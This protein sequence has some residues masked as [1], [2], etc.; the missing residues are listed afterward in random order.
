MTAL[1]SLTP[2]GQ[3]QS[4]QA[5]A[6]VICRDEA[7][8]AI[9]SARVVLTNESTG[10]SRVATT[11]K[12]GSFEARF[13]PLGRYRIEAS[14]PGFRT[15]TKSGLELSVGSKAA[16]EFILRI[17]AVEERIEVVAT[18]SQVETTNPLLSTL[19]DSRKI[20][21]LPLNGRDLVQLM[22]L[23]PGVQSARTDSGDIVTGSKGTRITV[24]G[25]RPSTNVFMLDG[26][27]INNL[28][29]RVAGGATGSLTGVETV[30]EF[31][32]Y[33][34]SY[35]AEFSRAA[36]GAFNIV[37]KSGTNALHGSAFE[38]LRN[39][40]LHARNFFD[41]QRPEFRRNQFGGSI[42][43]PIVKD[44]T[45]FF[46]SYE[47]FREQAGQTIIRTVPDADARLGRINGAL[48]GVAASVRPY[49]ALWPQPSSDP[50]PGDGSA[51]YTTVFSRPVTE[52]FFNARLD[53]QISS[54]DSLF[55]RYTI[56]DSAQTFLS[57]EAF[58]QYPN[59][60]TN[61]PQ[62]LTLQETKILS[63]F[64]I[65]ELRLGFAR[66]NPYEQLLDPSI[67]PDLAF[68]PGESLGVITIGGFD[69]FGPDRN[70]PRRLTQNSFQFSDQLAITRQRH[71][72]T[73]GLQ[74]ERLQ[75]NVISASQ[76]RGEFR[77]A[78]L[79][80]FLRA[81][82][83]TFEG[84]LPGSKDFTRGYRQ[85]LAGWYVQDAIKVSRRLTVNLGL[86]H[87]FVTVPTEQNGR[88]NN[89]HNFMDPRI[90]VGPPFTT[91]KANFAPRAGFALDPTGTGKT[92]IRGGIGFFFVPFVANQWWNSIVRLPPFTVTARATGAVA[93]FPAPVNGL[94]ALGRESISAI[95]YEHQQPYMLHFNF[96]VQ[97]AVTRSTILTVAYVGSRG[98]HLGRESDFNIG[99]PGNPVRRNPNFSRIRFRTWDARS[100][101]NS[102][103]TSLQRH[104]RGGAQFQLSYTLAKSVDDA[105][106]ELGRIEFNNGQARTSDPLDRLRDRGLSSFDIRQNLV[107][108][109]TWDLPWHRA[110]GWQLNGILTLSS[111][112]PFT[113][114]II[115]DL[116]QDGTDDNEQRPNLKPGRSKNPVL[117]R[118][119]H[120]FDVSAFES[121]AR[122]TRGNLGRNTISG[123]GL[124]ML[125]LSVARTFTLPK[126]ERARLQF[127][128]ESFNALNRANF[129]T[130][131]RSN[132][133]IFS[134][135]GPT[136]TPLPNAGR[137]NST[138]TSA[139]QSQLA[140]RLVF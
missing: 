44:R 93:P 54:T 48:V 2:R 29:N 73:A 108:N 19:I 124:A 75:Y 28:G 60:L 4:L 118:P 35:S 14:K 55:A 23:Q 9:S 3:A 119:E 111:G 122:G 68:I 20:S 97:R 88:M 137:I 64:A 5:S 47:G 77:F 129:S 116:D 61:R 16:F 12:D 131:P 139:R 96:N 138:V 10:L 53:H 89:L 72:F 6:S 57:D 70:V 7:G 135:A 117:G 120:W 27:V 106:G 104:F 92:A 39:D 84:I 99:S 42:G 113:P 83:S 38:F 63:S 76:L 50:V 82:V 103:Q 46:G 31:R 86:R 78:S 114:I 51:L 128:I 59:R 11:S 134:E 34:N 30:R 71:S 17:S 132:L 69:I 140:V 25:S 123:P 37:T 87:E 49:L 126:W 94:A 18:L 115:S 15:E 58:P 91:A 24:S 79:T 41:D 13:L 80:D 1:L 45:F 8:Q 40:N 110:R 33:T 67:R 112:A 52:N 101:Y 133:E 85:T 105:S 130:P 74:L 136:A 21:D 107:A 56:S 65:N 127:R 90:T 125:D 22:Q 36:G 98:I 66:S 95:E 26:T 109:S 102:L 32:A 100:F 43:G 121:I 62:F 81:S